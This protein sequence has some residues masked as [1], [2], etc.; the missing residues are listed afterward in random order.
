MSGGQ[1]YW[2]LQGLYMKVEFSSLT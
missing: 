2:G 1:L